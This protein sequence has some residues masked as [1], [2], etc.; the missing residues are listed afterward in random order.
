MSKVLVTG[1]CGFVGSH[2]AERLVRDGFEVAVADNLSTGRLDNIAGLNVRLYRCDILD[3]AFQQAVDDFLPDYIVHEAAQ[4]SV[5]KS[6]ENMTHDEAVNIQGTIRVIE[7]AKRCGAKKIVYAGSAAIYGDPAYLPVDEKHPVGPNSP[8]GIS[9]YVA[10]MYLRLAAAQFGIAYTVLRYS[11]V[12]G[13]R[14]NHIGEGGVVAKFTEAFRTG[15]TLTIHGDGE[16]TR[17]FVYAGDVAEANAIALNAGSGEAF[18]VSTG[19][20]ISVNTLLT[21][22]S[23]LIGVKPDVRYEPPRPGDIRHSVLSNERT[24]QK[25]GWMPQVTLREGLKRTISHFGI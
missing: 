16:Q 17:D 10:E 15:S 24:V 18:H 12:Y 3:P 19:T 22:M 8:Y 5:F 13:P 14:Q 1:G 25:L 21:E 20:K 7:A 9:K 23:E 6:T 11:N 2:I 4:A